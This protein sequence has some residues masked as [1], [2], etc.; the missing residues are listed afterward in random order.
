VRIT[1]SHLWS[2]PEVRRGAERELRDLALRQAAAGDQVRVVSGTRRGLVTRGS[3]GPLAL[4][5]VR[6]PR[7]GRLTDEAVWAASALPALA[8]TRADLLHAWHYGDGAAATLVRRGRPLVLKVTG[9]VPR[10]SVE[11]RRAD[12]S[13]LHRALEGASEVW[14]ND[15]WVV[16]AMAGWGVSMVVVPPGVDTDLFA[17]GGE[18][19]AQPTVL[20]VGPLSEPRKRISVL[21]QV[22]TARLRLAGEST[23]SEV[24]A[25][26]SGL[27]AR[28]RSSIMLLGSLGSTALR[29]EY[30]SA[31]VF[32]AP[33]G[34]EAFG[35]AVVEALAIGTPV[36]GTRTGATPGLLAGADLG[37]TL[38]SDDPGAMVEALVARLAGPPTEAE[39]AARSA[40]MARYSW[41]ARVA[42]VQDRYRALLGA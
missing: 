8:A 38:P 33:A 2:W 3:D 27:P 11:L 13:L 15:D 26:L 6:I 31:W 40:A 23:P 7:I 35:L 36:V 41:P 21:A 4:T 34:D 22:P 42:E 16:R 25:L 9:S 37:S 28:V 1:H 30:R 24:D 19:A 18:R 5:R 39:S 14:V 10:D 12:R 29:E 20:A 17:P 32:A